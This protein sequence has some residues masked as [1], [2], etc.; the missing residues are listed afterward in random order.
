MKAVI[1][2][3]TVKCIAMDGMTEKEGKTIQILAIILAIL[4]LA[5]IAMG[6]IHG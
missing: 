2:K 1:R 6:L 5:A 4:A 3:I